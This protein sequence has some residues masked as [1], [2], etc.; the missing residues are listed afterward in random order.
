MARPGTKPKYTKKPGKS[1]AIGAAKKPK[2]A[3]TAD[4]H[5]LYE[6]A[7]QCPEAE[8]DFVEETFEDLRGTK[9]RYLR[10]DFCGTAAAACE[11]I[12]RGPKNQAIGV[13]LD[14]E[15][16][17]WG[18]THH[19]DKLTPAQQARLEI[20][21]ENVLSV[22]TEPMDAILAMNFS[23]WIFKT[24]KL[25]RQYFENVHRGL[26][27]DGLFIMD[28]YGGHEAYEDD[29]REKRNCGKFTY[30]WE[31]ESYDPISGDYKC[32]IHFS[33]PDGSKMNNAF[34]YEWRLWSMPEIRELLEEA[35]FKKSTV[36]WQGDDEDDEEGE[37]EPV[38]VGDADPAWI[39]YIVAEK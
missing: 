34:S 24:R 27:D 5:A 30:I 22:K 36:Y 1:R 18:Q 35:G 11:W 37:F 14:E 31:Q 3:E 29:Y 7:V 10:E 26:A 4:R 15:V 8:M 17:A 19:I 16:L 20:R 6:D 33:F 13:D 23:Y 12:K 21:R 25:L 2:K 9:P 32:N 38:E 28:C 39:A